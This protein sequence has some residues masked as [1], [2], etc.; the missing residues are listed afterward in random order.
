MHKSSRT[1]CVHGK[2]I[3]HFVAQIATG[4]ID[5]SKLISHQFSLQLIE[6]AYDF[7]KNAGKTGSLKVLVINDLGEAAAPPPPPPRA[8]L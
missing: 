5:P 6:E 1:G 4:V 7:F 3:P 8:L 2:T